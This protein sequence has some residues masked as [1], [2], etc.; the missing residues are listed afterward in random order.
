M[1]I[2]QRKPKLRINSVVKLYM[3]FFSFY[4]ISYGN[5]ILELVELQPE[6]NLNSG[7][8]CHAFHVAWGKAV[9]TA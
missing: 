1:K 4:L 3:Y 8:V 5:N 9:S 7:L 6:L 2:T